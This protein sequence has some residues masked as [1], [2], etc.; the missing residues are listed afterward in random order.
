[1]A[2]YRIE[3][4]QQRDLL[5]LQTYIEEIIF[6]ESLKTFSFKLRPSLTLINLVVL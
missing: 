5:D 6:S 2:K 1:M 3:I 4:A